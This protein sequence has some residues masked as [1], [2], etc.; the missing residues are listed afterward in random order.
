MKRASILIGFTPYHAYAAGTIIDLLKDE[1][2]CA[3]TKL[4][5][6]SNRK[7]IRLG[8]STSLHFPAK[9]IFTFLHLAA[10]VRLLVARGYAI[11]VYIPHPGHIFSN[12]L[13]FAEIANKRL[14]IYEDGILNY[15][16]ATTSN[17]F[18]NTP[19]RILAMV[20][21]MPYRGYEG[22]LAGYD[23]GSYHGAFLTMPE[24]AVRRQRL[25]KLEKLEFK[26]NRITTQSKF[27]LFLDQN[28]SNLLTAE[29]RNSCI[30]TMQR[31]YPLKEYTYIYKP[32]HDYISDISKT[33][34]ILDSDLQSLP[35]EMLIEHLRPSH[36]ISF[37][38]S[39]LINI[40]RTWPEV[41]CISLA[42]NKIPI[43]RDGRSTL[44][45]EIFEK[46][47]VYCLQMN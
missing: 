17:P 19:K 27:I 9:G 6:T 34:K 47:G 24:M 1:V 22:H 29:E 42:A 40:K 43:S 20:C 30:Q 16:D 38:S 45:S 31:C 26:K 18:I 11:D 13:F 2:Y 23:V 28:V 41:T 46:A 44:L 37:F 5:P 14:F 3:F 15:Y 39:A 25:G 33:M 12:Y 21:G 32:H 7:Y 35:A 8:L 4:W 10:L 36:V